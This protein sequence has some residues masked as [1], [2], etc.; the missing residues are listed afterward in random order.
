MVTESLFIILAHTVY[1]ITGIK[2]VKTLSQ[3]IGHD[4]NKLGD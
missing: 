2:Q 3:Y 4:R 1:D